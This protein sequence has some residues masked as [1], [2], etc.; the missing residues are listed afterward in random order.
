MRGSRTIRIKTTKAEKKGFTVAL[1]ATAAGAK[2]PAV[3]I[4]KERNEILGERIKKKL[5]IPSNVRVQASTNGWMTAAEYRAC[6]GVGLI[7]SKTA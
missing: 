5:N 6:V 1:A 4:F 3:I 7:S 2:L